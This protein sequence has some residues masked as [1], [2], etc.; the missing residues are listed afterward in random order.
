[1]LMRL[2]LVTPMVMTSLSGIFRSEDD[3]GRSMRSFAGGANWVVVM[4]KMSSRNATSTMGVMSMLIPMRFFF[5]NMPQDLP[6]A[7]APWSAR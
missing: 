5:F 3:S 2:S 1:M 6:E 7:T 4:K